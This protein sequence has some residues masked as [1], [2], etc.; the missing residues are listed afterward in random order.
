[1]T[2]EQSQ[3]F[4]MLGSGPCVPVAYVRDYYGLAWPLGDPE[5][6]FFESY[7]RT[8]ARRDACPDG[9]V[10]RYELEGFMS[11]NDVLTKK[12]MGARLGI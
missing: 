7:I 12:W 3:R 10:S 4:E 1:M 9:H 11:R 6:R 5:A 8:L 2:P